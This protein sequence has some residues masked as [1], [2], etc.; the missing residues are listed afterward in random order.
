MR[1]FEVR[2]PDRSEA[3]SGASADRFELLVTQPDLCER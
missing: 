1:L 2:L 3:V